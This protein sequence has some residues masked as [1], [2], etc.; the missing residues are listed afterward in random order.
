MKKSR[1]GV[2]L[3]VMCHE[4]SL[5]AIER[6]LFEETTTLGVRRCRWTRRVLDRRAVEVETPFGRIQGKVATL[7]DG[8]E[9]FSPEFDSCRTVAEAAGVPLQKIYT[10]ANE[11]FGQF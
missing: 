2:L 5:S 10:A 1:P 4:A 8:T 9:R 7:P 11:S 6:I 3:S